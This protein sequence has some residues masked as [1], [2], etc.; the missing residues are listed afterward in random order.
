M[1][2]ELPESDISGDL[3]LANAIAGLGPPGVRLM[4]NGRSVS[5]LVLVDV[6]SNVGFL[7]TIEHTRRNG[8]F[9]NRFGRHGVQ[10]G[11]WVGLL[12]SCN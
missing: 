6:G 4:A 11:Q 5:R 8:V 12:Y 2:H 10:S 1:S 9:G 7:V 3:L